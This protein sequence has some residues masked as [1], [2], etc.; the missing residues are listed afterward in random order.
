MIKIKTKIS[1]YSVLVLVVIVIVFLFVALQSKPNFQQGQYASLVAKKTSEAVNNNPS[2]QSVTRNIESIEKDIKA[3]IDQ[4][5]NALENS[6]NPQSLFF[7]AALNGN[8]EEIKTILVTNPQINVNAIDGSGETALM[9]AA[10]G[11]HLEPVKYLLSHGAGADMCI[12]SSVVG[13]LPTGILT[14]VKSKLPYDHPNREAI[15]NMLRKK[16]GK[17]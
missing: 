12:P 17:E 8:I 3:P 6:T 2:I 7:S 13:G 5:S 14:L 9:K 10:S 15:L 4:F 16:G 11:G 1:K